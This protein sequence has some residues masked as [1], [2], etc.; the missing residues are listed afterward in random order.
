MTRIDR[1]TKLH[2]RQNFSALSTVNAMVAC[3]GRCRGEATA[4]MAV[5]VRATVGRWL[6]S[7]LWV[8]LG[9]N[10]GFFWNSFDASI[11]WGRNHG[12]WG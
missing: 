1:K 8:E 10:I 5:E 9:K 3:Q 2:S 12:T 11:R 4:Q 7:K 6:R